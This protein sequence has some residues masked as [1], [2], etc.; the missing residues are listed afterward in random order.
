[1]G[2]FITLNLGIVRKQLVGFEFTKLLGEGNRDIVVSVLLSFV[3]SI[4][5]ITLST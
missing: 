3:G 2:I 5:W 1:M 4:L